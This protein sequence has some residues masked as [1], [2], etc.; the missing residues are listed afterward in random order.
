MVYALAQIDSKGVAMLTPSLRMTAGR[1]VAIGQSDG[2][3]SRP[4]SKLHIKNKRRDFRAA[5]L[6]L[7]FL[8]FH[9]RSIK[10]FASSLSKRLLFQALQISMHCISDALALF[11]GLDDGLCALHDVA[12]GKHAL[13]G[14][15]AVFGNLREPSL[16]DF[17]TFRLG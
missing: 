14:G 16:V 4:H 17:K 2:G 1:A 15:L 5:I 12:A 6:F 10:S 13:A 3:V 9:I 8:I 7:Y 11:G